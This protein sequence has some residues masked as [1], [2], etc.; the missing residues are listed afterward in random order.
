[1]NECEDTQNY[2]FTPSSKEAKKRLGIFTQAGKVR[3]KKMI[4]KTSLCLG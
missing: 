3:N 2:Y 1:M 4:N